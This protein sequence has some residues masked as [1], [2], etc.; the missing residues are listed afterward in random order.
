[1][2]AIMISDARKMVVTEVSEP[3]VGDDTVKVRVARCGICGTDLAARS[4]SLPRWHVG[5]VLG[6]EVVGEIDEVG[7]AVQNWSPGDRVAL[8]M[9]SPCGSCATCRAGRGFLCIHHLD[10][11]L[12]H[13][14][15]QGG[16]ASHIVVSPELLH[17]I[18][19]H[20][21]FDQ[22]AIAEPLAIA[23]HGVNRSNVRPG[24]S[25]AILGAGPIG[26]LTA[27]ALRA[28]GVDDIVLV[29]PN[30]ARRALMPPAGFVA[31][32][33]AGCEESVPAALGGRSPEFIFECTSHLSAPGKAVE[34]AAYG[35]RIVL[36]G[37][38][39][40]PVQ[41]SQYLVVQKEL[42]LVGSASC[43]HRDM[44]EAISHLAAGR[45]RAEDFVTAVVPLEQADEMFDALL[46]P[47]GSHLKVLLAPNLPAPVN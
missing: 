16:Y 31:V 45:V 28:R 30:P 27:A 35:A 25:V 18:P 40:A 6:H 7:A 24:D 26:A 17:H 8:S 4:S 43:N 47:A 15:V 3:D 1:M 46:D 37:V 21:S 32:D 14:V 29:D 23:I 5:C 2:K 9:G 39:K 19:D 42:E 44:E 10:R 20:L 12:G 33:L 13:G 36:Q 38:P 34:L 22:A 41:V 11:A